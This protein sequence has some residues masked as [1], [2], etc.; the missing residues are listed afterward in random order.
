MLIA[1]L[2]PL[3]AFRN[4]TAIPQL[5]GLQILLQLQLVPIF[6]LKRNLLTQPSQLHLLGQYTQR[7]LRVSIVGL[8]EATQ[9]GY[10]LGFVVD[11]LEAPPGAEGVQ[12]DEILAV[13]AE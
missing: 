5:L 10:L 11:A 2:C 8:A 12:S 1:F 13:E 3:D 6:P 7:L 9:F 4:F